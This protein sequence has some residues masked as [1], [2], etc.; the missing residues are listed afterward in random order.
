MGKRPCPILPV[1]KR[2]S[3]AASERPWPRSV[4]V[5]C[6]AEPAR[7]LVRAY[8]RALAHLAAH[9]G[10]GE[11]IV[12]LEQAAAPIGGP[13]PGGY[14]IEFAAPGDPP[15][16]AVSA[17]EAAGF[18][19]ALQTLRQ[20][21]CAP[22]MPVGRIEDW[23]DLSVRGFHLNFESYRRLDV[24]GAQH[25]LET[26][27][28]YKLN[29]LLV[30]YGPRFPFRAQPLIRDPAALAEADLAR[31]PATADALGLDVIP[32]Q[33]T[34]AHLDYALRHEPLAH[35]RERPDKPDLLCPLH[36]ESLPLVESLLDEVVTAHPQSRFIHLGGDEARKVGHCPRCAAAV[37]EGG[38]G[39]LIGRYLGRLAQ[40]V[41]DHGRRPVLWDDT[42][43]TFPDAFAHIP[44]PTVIQ[45]WD[46]IAVADPTPVLIPRL[47]HA[48]GGPRVA[49]DWSWNLPRRRARL[50]DVQRDVMHHYSEATPLKLLDRRFLDEYRA[51][52][53]P[54]FP[55]LI[56][57][58]PYLE[59]YQQRGH[60]VILS[61]TGMGNGDVT[62][63]LPNFR[64]FEANIRT[65]AAR[66]KSNGRALGLITTAW[67]DMPPEW[68][69]QPLLLTAQCAW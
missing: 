35:L 68:L 46:Y 16:V 12:R 1:P 9:G 69:V 28:A 27:A 57:A 23:P 30:E 62:D 25:L 58:L 13:H 32:L 19:H 14:T 45:Y 4:R 11:L 55:R 31:L 22:A 17:R 49:H 20:L 21:A 53:G 51:F 7:E 48:R 10:E 41:L 67:Y 36:P 43:C 66:A 38:H 44:R 37:R 50:S 63:G 39:T 54:Q 5:E 47:A 8:E 26:A 56:R 59:Y 64:R 3:L 33:Q 15:T 60:D 65:H 34:L 6:A 29:T 61:P 24:D 40:R 18:R 2:M 52:L 42:L